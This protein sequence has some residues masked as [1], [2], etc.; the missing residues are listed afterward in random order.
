M[1]TWNTQ[2]HTHTHFITT[3]KLYTLIVL[4]LVMLELFEHSNVRRMQNVMAV[5]AQL[6]DGRHPRK[7]QYYSGAWQDFLPKVANVVIIL[8]NLLQWLCFLVSL[9]NTIP[10]IQSDTET[11]P[12]YNAASQSA[13]CYFL[14]FPVI[15]PFK[16]LFRLVSTSHWQ[17]PTISHSLLQ[18]MKGTSK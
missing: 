1:R 8:V 14:L 16:W 13:L 12:A 9:K 3:F 7:L 17:L 2:T 6:Y 10:M 18:L 5:M 4:C 11:G 15:L